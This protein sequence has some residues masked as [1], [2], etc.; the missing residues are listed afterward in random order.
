MALRRQRDDS[1][2]GYNPGTGKFFITGDNCSLTSIS[3]EDLLN[4]ANGVPAGLRV[5]L[6]LSGVGIFDVWG[7]GLRMSLR[8]FCELVVQISNGGLDR[9]IKSWSAV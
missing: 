5:E 6:A 2:L 4:M 1:L 8:E 9:A 3:S 7:F